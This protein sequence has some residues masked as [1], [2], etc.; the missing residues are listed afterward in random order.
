MT[1]IGKIFIVLIL[2]MSIVF[3]SFAVCV[4]S[5]HQNW[6]DLGTKLNA[7]LVRARQTNSERQSEIEQLKNRSALEKAARREALAVLEQKA[8]EKDQLFQETNDKFSQLFAQHET[9]ISNVERAQ[10]QLDAIKKQNQDLRR[11]IAETQQDRDDQFAKA[12]DLTDKLANAQGTLV[13]LEQRQQKLVQQFAQ[14]QTVLKAHDLTIDSPVTEIP[15]SLNGEVVSVGNNLIKISLGRH[16]GL[17][18]GHQVE[19]SRKDRYLGRGEITR[20]DLDEAV[21]KVNAFAPIRKGD[22]VQTKIR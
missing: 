9:L 15:P 10:K 19:V 2:I 7:D 3:M 11:N 6:K 14:A 16:D 13:A 21:A 12:R 8:Q 22:S 20:V 1:L 4:Y 5:T 17:K 18:R